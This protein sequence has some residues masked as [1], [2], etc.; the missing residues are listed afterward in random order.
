[1]PNSSPARLSASAKRAAKKQPCP[2]GPAT[3][4]EARALMQTV[5]DNMGEGVALFDQEFRLQFINRQCMDFQNYP[6]D[7]AYPGASGYD[8]L[9]FQIERG[10]FGKVTDADRILS[11]R[12]SLMRQPGGY[13]YNRRT[14]GGQHVEFNFKPLTDGGVLV[15]CRD[16][17]ELKRVEESLRAAGDVLKVISRPGFSLQTVLDKLVVS[18][19][20]L[21]DADSSFVFCLGRTTYRL[22]SSYGF[23]D[24]YRDYMMR[25][26]IEPG[27]HTLVGRTALEG[28]MVHIPDCL[29]DPEYKWFEVRKNWAASALCWASHFCGM[30]KRLVSLRSLARHHDPLPK[31]IST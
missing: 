4:G 25:Q 12:T 28:A 18:A 14:A 10:D 22:S 1:M 20:H 23:S 17:T 15:V 5:L 11:E 2:D 13:H 7:I 24:E 8:M 19:A 27:P 31:N 16:I 3:A 26:R 29:A 9:R 21:C 6:A 30:D